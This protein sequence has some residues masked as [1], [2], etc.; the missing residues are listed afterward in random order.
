MEGSSSTQLEDRSKHSAIKPTE[1]L[2]NKHQ[3]SGNGWM[4]YIMNKKNDIIRELFEMT[5][6]RHV[7]EHSDVS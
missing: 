2:T 6:Q 4:A 5:S 7:F 3:F 1:L